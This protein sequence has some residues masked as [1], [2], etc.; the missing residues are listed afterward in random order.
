M[1]ASS[2]A[3]AESNSPW[4]YVLPLRNRGDDDEGKRERGRRDGYRVAAAAAA[5]A[6]K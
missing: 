6:V 5:A 2:R 3:R 4:T 1:H